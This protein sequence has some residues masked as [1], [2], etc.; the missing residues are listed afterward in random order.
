MSEQNGPLKVAVLMGGIGSERAVSLES[1]RSVVAALGEA[2]FTVV[3]HDLDP[4]NLA[5]LDDPSIHVFFPALHGTF[6]EDGQLQEIMADRGL[7]FVGSDGPACTCSF[8][9]QRTKQ[10]VHA[11][12]VRT[13][14]A[15]TFD[16]AASGAARATLAPWAQWVVKPVCQGSSV[17][18]TLCSDL[19]ETLATAH[20]THETYG[21]CMIERF[22]QGREVTVGVVL[23]QVLPVIEIRPECG[24]YDYH[25]KYQAEKTEYLF[26]T[27]PA[28]VCHELSSLTRIGFEALGMRH[29]GRLDFLVGSDDVPWFLEANAIPGLTGHSLLPKAAQRVGLPM[30]SLC[31][32]L[33]HAA[34]APRCEPGFANCQ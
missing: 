26:D 10:A 17:G 24:F 14:E 30:P 22:V 25:A 31:A 13:P 5:I 8:D 19:D 4:G 21:N 23:D 34:A 6:G 29:F 27:V 33:V 2:G 11:A 28:A 1:G 3:S 15:I 32:R 20:T 7:C 12:G 9:K 16:P 18:V